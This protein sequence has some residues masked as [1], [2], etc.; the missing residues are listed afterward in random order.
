LKLEEHERHSPLEAYEMH[1][2]M[3]HV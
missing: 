3:K 2:I 1:P